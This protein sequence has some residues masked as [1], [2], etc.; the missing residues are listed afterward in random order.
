MMTRFLL[1]SIAAG[2]GI[3]ASSLAVLARQ[4]DAPTD[5]DFSRDI[6]PILADH[7]FACHGPDA[8][9]READ[10]R[11]DIR[12]KAIESKVIVPGDARASE[13]VQRI[14]EHDHDLVMPPP[15]VKQR[16]TVAEKAT[17]RRW[18][19][20]GAS[21][22]EHWAFVAPRRPALPAVAKTRW[23]RNAIDRFVLAR[24]EK[25]A[26]TPSSVADRRTLIRR[27]SLDL[28]GLPPTSQEVRSLIEDSSANAYEKVVDRLLASPRFGERMAQ[29]WL[30]FARYADSDGYHDDTTRA[31]WPYRD[32][33]IQSF[34]KNKGFDKFTREQIAGDQ[35]PDATLEQKVA[36]AFHRNGPTSSEGGADPEEYRV[37]Y[38]VDRV[39][40][41]A[42]VWLG[43]TLQCAEC[44]DHK[45][46][47][48]TQREF[49]QLFAFF[50][51]VPGNN[52]YRGLYAPP[53]IK[54]PT[55]Q[56]QQRHVALRQQVSALESQLRNG[57]DSEIKQ[58]IARLNTEPQYTRRTF[59][60]YA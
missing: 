13:L 51:Q 60:N 23:P 34:N 48:F 59:R 20:A 15:E 17:L 8:K 21:Y 56:F 44:H 16:L 19:E 35:F 12:D 27:L 40:T 29:H 6:R 25:K 33:V 45:Y 52:L 24:L 39:N 3:L 11:L 47:P 50:D 49:Y 28:T 22:S 18:I 42:S 38:A 54:V 37:K 55:E 7:C 14:N 32:Y 10:L 30:D 58:Q 2:A 26:L 1:T 46:D 9:Q 31:M 57:S 41:T 36:S 5:V 4:P 53:S 43:V